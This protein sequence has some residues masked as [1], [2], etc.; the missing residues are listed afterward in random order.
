MKPA[1]EREVRALIVLTCEDAVLKPLFRRLE[2]ELIR[3]LARVDDPRVIRKYL[4]H[5]MAVSRAWSASA[6]VAERLR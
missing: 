5:L 3:V 6:V 1:G 2:Q 4:E